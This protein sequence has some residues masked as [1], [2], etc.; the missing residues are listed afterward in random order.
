MKNWI[1]SFA[2]TTILLATSS[3]AFADVTASDA[4]VRGTVDGQK[5]TAAFM[6]LKS[7]EATQLVKGSSPVAKM[8]QIHQETMSGGMMK[9][10][11]VK[12][13]DLPANSA[14][15]LKPGTYHVMLMGLKKPLAKGEM[16]PVK[17]SFRDKGGAK[18][19]LEVMAEVRELTE[20]N[21]PMK[22]DGMKD[23]MKMQH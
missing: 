15:E 9:M 22:M 11:P 7:S 20:P 2:A 4:W 1:S 16:V 21:A 13:L 19:T 12:A 6:T 14:V 18:S 17:L 23:D 3:L 8:V 5:E 10:R